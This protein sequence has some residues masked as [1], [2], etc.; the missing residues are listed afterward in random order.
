MT[1]K[2]LTPKQQ[3]FVEEYLLDLNATAAAKRAGYSK[4]T[5]Q[6]I[7]SEN[8]AKP[9]IAEAI[10]K[11]RERHTAR[12]DVTVDSLTKEYEEARTL[13]LET[14]QSSAAV[15]ATT[16]KAKLHGM[17]TDKQDVAHTGN[18]NFN[19]TIQQKPK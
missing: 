1:A 14:N 4:H 17:V 7:G 19:T 3:R 13:A 8:L 15:S 5:A 12:C 10:Q 16:G 9:I 18:I 11:A 2:K 6:V